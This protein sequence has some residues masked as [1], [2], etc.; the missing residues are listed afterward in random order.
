MELLTILAAAAAEE[1]HSET[2]F[3]VAGG[4]LAAFG[5]LAGALGIARHDLPERLCNALMGVGAL[6]VVGTMV[7]VIVS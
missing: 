3:F 5:V 7:S 4:L 2:A 1:G 6:L